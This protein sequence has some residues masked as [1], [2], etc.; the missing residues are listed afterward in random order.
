V[1]C[2]K[3]Q[4]VNTRPRSRKQCRIQRRGRQTRRIGKPSRPSDVFGDLLIESGAQ[5][6]SR[7]GYCSRCQQVP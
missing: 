3:Q 5:A 6:L 1:S 2:S 4:R 7:Q